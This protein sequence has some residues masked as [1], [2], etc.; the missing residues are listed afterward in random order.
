MGVGTLS[1]LS[2]QSHGIM[3]SLVRI[4]VALCTHD[5]IISWALRWRIRPFSLSLSL[6]VYRSL[7]FFHVPFLN[8]QQSLICP[9]LTRS[10]PWTR[11]RLSESASPTEGITV[12]KRAWKKKCGPPPQE[13]LLPLGSRWY[14][15]SR[16]EWLGVATPRTFL[17][18]SMI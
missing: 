4:M 6:S 7:F 1:P 2:V 11:G 18:A 15:R 10:F 17:F 3:V 12:E 16:P 8:S 5:R 9:T 14:T 13:K